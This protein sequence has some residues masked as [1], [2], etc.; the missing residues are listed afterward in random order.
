MTNVTT[1]TTNQYG[2]AT[3]S[4]I[5]ANN[6]SG[7]Y[8]ISAQTAGA[9]SASF[10]IA[11]MVWYVTP[12]GNDSTNSCTAP[13][14]PC[15]SI[16]GVF[17]KAGFLS[18]DTVYVSQGTYV[19]AGAQ[20]V[21]IENINTT[22][23]GGWNISFTNQSGYSTLDGQNTRAGLNI[24]PNSNTRISRFEVVNSIT[25]VGNNPSSTLILDNGSI[26]NNT[27]YTIEN[28]GNLTVSNSNI[29]SNTTTYGGGIYSYNSSNNSIDL[30]IMNTAVYTMPRIM[31]REEYT[32]L[33]NQNI[34][35][36]NTTIYNN[37]GY[38]GGSTF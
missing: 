29:F 24:G 31:A 7:S 12:A 33:N 17:A 27:Y 9:T 11:N 8:L 35:I 4:N 18:G 21:L 1:A 38:D 6:Q 30:N 32:T 5:T 3:L 34:S 10:N 2:L 22:I 14:S 15:A 26:H 20:T 25:G 13:A 16:N 19:G 28:Y 36:T 37:S 23:S